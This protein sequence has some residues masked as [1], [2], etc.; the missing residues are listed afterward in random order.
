M[1]YLFEGNYS[2]Y[3]EVTFCDSKGD[4]RKGIDRIDVISDVVIDKVLSAYR[5]YYIVLSWEICLIPKR[6]K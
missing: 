4:V 1:K 3:M 5:E 2:I 6:S